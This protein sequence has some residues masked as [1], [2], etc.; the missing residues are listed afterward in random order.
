MCHFECTVA[1]FSFTFGRDKT[2]I[3][4]LIWRVHIVGPK[5]CWSEEL[6]VRR[7][8]G[9]KSRWSEESLVRRVV[10]PKVPKYM[11]DVLQSAT[12]NTLFCVKNG[13]YV[14]WLNQELNWNKGGPCIIFRKMRD[15]KILFMIPEWQVKCIFTSKGLFGM[16]AYQFPLPW[17]DKSDLFWLQDLSCPHQAAT[18]I[19]LP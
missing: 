9:P 12:S 16:S 2:T 11:L 19:V 3:M 6:L 18:I 14:K 10:G 17:V 5:S 15:R 13:W 7:V 4:A 8:V 1:Y